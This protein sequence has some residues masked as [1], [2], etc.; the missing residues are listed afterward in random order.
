MVTLTDHY[1]HF[2][3]PAQ[4]HIYSATGHTHYDLNHA[5]ITRVGRQNVA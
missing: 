3:V 4:R 2:V 1:M 5:E